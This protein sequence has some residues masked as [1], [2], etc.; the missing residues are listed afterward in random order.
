MITVDDI[1]S[2]HGKYLE[3]KLV[4]GE[5]GLPKAIK[6]PE[7]HRPGLSLSGYVKNFP[8]WRVLVFGKL[9]IEY[10]NELKQETRI[11]RLEKILL[12]NTPAIFLARNFSPSKEIRKICIDQKIPLFK[13]P[14]PTSELL[15]KLFFILSEEFAPSTTI[16]GTLVE[17]FGMGVLL[18]G[19]SSVGKSE[20]ALGLLER[21][22]RLIADD[23]VKIKK[24]G[25]ELIGSGPELTRHMMEIRG[26]G[27]INVA[28]LH[29]AVCVRPDIE[30]DLVVKLEEWDNT[31]FYDRVG[32]EDKHCD[33]LGIKVPYHILPVKPG[34]DVI[35]LIETLA[36][37]H[38]LKAVGYN[39]AKEFNSKLLETI[40]RRNSK[41]RRF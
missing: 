37:N 15:T 31:Q 19:E 33:F 1:Y 20:A 32:L 17:V 5:Q 18:Q 38:R 14:M 24:R 3:L 36:L 11:K 9:E 27:I 39:S 4:V 6:K 7:I 12:P 22:H 28:N 8:S 10:L 29:G 41:K 25:A 40:Q 13:T 23:A 34:R 30:V 21:G 16:H 35:L 26:I 2:E